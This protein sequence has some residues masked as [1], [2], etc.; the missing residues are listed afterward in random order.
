MSRR[1]G[2]ALAA[3]GLCAVSAGPTFAATHA[4][5]VCN[6]P[7]AQHVGAPAPGTQASYPAGSAGSV[8]VQRIDAVTLQV[9]RA[10]PSAGWTDQVVT[11][12]G[13]KDKV[14]FL[15]AASGQVTRFAAGLN[16]KG[17]E[18]HLRVTECHH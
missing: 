12:S 8:D 3:I 18:I 5:L 1:L 17:T 7:N 16:K 10:N 11:G 4:P 6:P 14:R 9:V 2:V 13:P 15:N